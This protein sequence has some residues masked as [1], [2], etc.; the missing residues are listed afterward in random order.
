LHREHLRLA[1]HMLSRHGFGE[2][3]SRFSNALKSLTAEAGK[4]DAYH[5]TMTVAYLA[6]IGERRARGGSPTWEEF[7]AANA[8]LLEKDCLSRW[9]SAEELQSDIARTTFVLPRR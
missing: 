5:E 1:F 4:P 8:D 6:I 7:I 9:Y 3:V 2:A